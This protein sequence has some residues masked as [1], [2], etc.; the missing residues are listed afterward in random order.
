MIY[1]S[2]VTYTSWTFAFEFEFLATQNLAAIGT[3][4]HA[5][6]ETFCIDGTSHAEISITG[7]WSL[8]VT[9]FA[10]WKC[11]FPEETLF[12]LPSAFDS[13]STHWYFSGFTNLHTSGTVTVNT[14]NTRWEWSQTWT[15]G[16]IGS[17]LYTN[18]MTPTSLSLKWCC[19]CI[20]I[21]WLC[22]ISWN[23]C[24]CYPLKKLEWLSIEF[25]PS[26]KKSTYPRCSI[27][28]F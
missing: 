16:P 27:L 17:S 8:R 9:S 6:I 20:I 25:L 26:N 4:S 10:F 3:S 22:P 18:W 15:H 19:S 14:S 11:S 12:S 21:I 7:S 13:S 23:N 28:S 2:Q 5:N 1:R 24:G